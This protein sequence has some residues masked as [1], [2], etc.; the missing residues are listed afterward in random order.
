VRPVLTGLAVAA[1]TALVLLAYPLWFRFFGDPLPHRVPVPDPRLGEDPTTLALYWRDTLAGNYTAARV[2][3]GIEQNTWF[4]W[5]LLILAG[6]CIAG[7]WARSV[8]VRA[9][10]LTA[11]VFGI[12]ALGAQIRLNGAPTPVPGPWWL[13]AHLPGFNLIAPTHL[14]LVPVACLAVLLAVAYDLLPDGEP[15][16]YGL[17]VRRMSVILFVAALIPNVPKPVQAN[18]Q[19]HDV[20]KV[21][22]VAQVTSGEV[23]R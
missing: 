5:P 9:V 19:L 7:A 6:V 12:L 13:F 4:G 21:A 2:V 17:T 15:V 11:L 16:R 20:P 23:P 3:G 22:A 10:T 18:V 8:A 14:A 1:G